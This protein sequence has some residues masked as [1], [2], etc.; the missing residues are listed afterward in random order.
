MKLMNRRSMFLRVLLVS[1][2]AQSRRQAGRVPGAA[3]TMTP[4]NPTISAAQARPFTASGTVH[5]DRRFEPAAN[6]PCVRLSD[7][8]AK[9]TGRNQFGQHGD[10]TSDGF[11]GARPGQRH[12]HGDAGHRRRR[13]RVRAACERHGE[14]LG[15]GRVRAARRRDLRN[16]RAH[17]RRGERPH[18]RRRPRGRVWTRAARSSR[19]PRCGAGARTAKGSSGTGPPPIPV[20][21]SR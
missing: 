19:T 3:V 4:A 9:C 17:S 20:P 16:L 13:V 11:L 15:I 21:P 7:G 2:L 8:T 6:T 10:G 1:P 18:R 14:V 5:T 12:H